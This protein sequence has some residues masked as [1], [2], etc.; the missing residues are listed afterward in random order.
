MAKKS[1][2][3]GLLITPT[4]L[5]KGVLN[6]LRSNEISILT[7]AA[8]TGKDFIQM[9]RAIEGLI[10]KEFD[11]V[12]LFRSA[13]EIGAGI[14][15]LPGE[16]SDKLAPY[17]RV[18]FEHLVKMVDKSVMSRIKNKIKFEHIGFVRGLSF[19]HSAVILTEAQ[20]LTLHELVSLST[21][22]SSSS[23]MFVNGDERQ[24]DIGRKSGLKDFISIVKDIEGV[25]HMHLGD[26]FQMRNALITE[27]DNKYCKF[28]EKSV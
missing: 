5:Q 23:K 19:E 14:G 4:K 25:G 18:F 10:N 22:L 24:A 16:E 28:L 27:I 13:V 11:E 3:N 1:G 15:Y 8:G 20:N 9:Y 26:E 6:F 2:E 21:R 17:K 7:G 12:I